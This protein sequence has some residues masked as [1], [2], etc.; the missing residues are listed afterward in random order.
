[1][2]KRLEDWLGETTNY[3]DLTSEGKKELDTLMH[4]TERAKRTFEMNEKEYEDAKLF[5]LEHQNCNTTSAMSER[6]SYTFI[7]GGV[8]TCVN[9]KCIICGNE[10]NITDV[11]SW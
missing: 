7:P 11:D 1:M 2:G 6:F 5:V 10:K 9:V 4:G 3:S 8:G